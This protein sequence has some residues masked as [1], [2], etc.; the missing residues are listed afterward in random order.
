LTKDDED[1]EDLDSAL[2]SIL[3]GSGIKEGDDSLSALISTKK[4]IHMDG[5]KPVPDV[6]LK[7]E[8][9]EEE[10]ESTSDDLTITNPYWIKAGMKQEVVDLL[11]QKGI[12][13]FTSVQGTSFEPILSG[14]DMICRSRTGTGKTLAFGIPALHRS[15]ELLRTKVDLTVMVDSGRVDHLPCW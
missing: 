7:E 4:K 8:N 9:K 11:S 15:S 14:R 13:S 10:V 12:T 1:D 2:N 5:S 6:L 3:S